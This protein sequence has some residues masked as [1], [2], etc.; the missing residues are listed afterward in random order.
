MPLLTS[1]HAPLGRLALAALMT[2]LLTACGGGDSTQASP[3][4][5]APTD[6]MATF[7][8]QKLNWKACD[9][10]LSPD[11]NAI[12]AFGERV[13]C[14]LMRAPLDYA[15]PALG[16][17]Q[18]ALLKVSAERPD[19]R[20]G[21]ILVNPGGPG[22]DGLILP[23]RFTQLFALANP[24]DP[25][26]KLLKEMSNRYDLI[27]FSPRGVGA[28]SALTCSSP[29]LLE[30]EDSLT[31]DR[32]PDNIQKV[33]H[34]TRLKT[35]SCAKNPLT[36]HIN[37]DATARD[38][39][40]MRSLLGDTQLNLIGFS[41][42]TWLGTW[43]AS[44]FPERVG[45]MLFDSSMNVAGSYDDATLLQ[46][47]GRQRVIDELILPYAARHGQRFNL[48]R[49]ANQIRNAILALPLP[50][51]SLLVS[52]EGLN[53]GNSSGAD[54]NPVALTAAFGL[55]A[56]RQQL[57]QA[58]VNAI[59]AAI[60]AYPFTPSGPDNT[61]AANQAHL[62]AAKL[63]KPRERKSVLVLPRE[64][65]HSAM[66]CNDMATTGDEQHWV[67]IGH[68]YA[69]RYPL[70]GGEATANPCLYWSP[71][72]VTRPPLAAAAQASPLL[73]LQS[74]YDPATPVEGAQKTLAALPKASMIVIENEYT[75]AL[76]PYG[77]NCVDGKVADYFVTGAMPP[78]TS[79]CAGKPL[80]ADAPSTSSRQAKAASASRTYTDAVKAAEA[81]RQI[82]EIT[83][84]A[85][86][87]RF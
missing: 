1:A 30:I 87:N 3:P 22:S 62:F 18:V 46:E 74:R 77:D 21:A 69:S 27:G 60:D 64:A 28:S 53:V 8:Q 84:Q 35:Q 32:S 44:L 82:H 68:D 41:Y 16:E 52:G 38:M 54:Q 80:P 24:A 39:D 57:P 6:A 59:H 23:F 12:N 56:L 66:I 10:T 51:K 79:S 49:D 86:R 36:K 83:R 42:G 34:N 25:T 20:T 45:R 29:E 67:D 40:L 5:P 78:R 37:T 63:F 9:P 81:M 85:G 4:T 76:F 26:G 50:L 71:P 7:T 47:M 2:T 17:L 55:N 33:Q 73:M 31:F 65:A 48:S 13:K 75:H 19:Q 15:N 43:Y 14:T 72:V 61:A 70:T 11:P 58:D